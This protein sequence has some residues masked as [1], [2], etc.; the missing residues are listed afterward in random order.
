MKTYNRQSSV[1]K[2]NGLEIVKYIKA[3][4]KRTF[5][6]PELNGKPVSSTMFARQYDAEEL[7]KRVR[8]N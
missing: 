2:V 1:S 8:F 5:F 6:R 3:G 4:T 7:A